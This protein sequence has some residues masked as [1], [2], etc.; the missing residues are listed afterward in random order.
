MRGHWAGCESRNHWR[1]DAILREDDTRSRNPGVVTNLALLRNAVIALFVDHQETY[2]SLP[3]FI[4]AVAH[5]PSFARR[6]VMEP[7]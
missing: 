2:G 6:L 3:A 1:R 7:G 5:R 4:E